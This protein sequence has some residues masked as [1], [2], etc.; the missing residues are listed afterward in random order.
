[1]YGDDNITFINLGINFEAFLDWQVSLEKTGANRV[2]YGYLN[3]ENSIGS[4]KSYLEIDNIPYYQRIKCE[5][6]SGRIKVLFQRHQVLFESAYHYECNES[7]FLGQLFLPRLQNAFDII[8]EGDNGIYN[9]IIEGLDYIVPLAKPG[10]QNHPSFASALLK[11]TIFLSLDLLETSDV[12]LAECIIHEFGHCQLYKV[13]D[14]VLLTQMDLNKRYYYSPWRTDPRHL[15]GLVHGIYVFSC[16]IDFYHQ[17]LRKSS[18][19]SEIREWVYNRLILLVYQ[20][21]CA[22][23]QVRKDEIAQAGGILLNDI[24]RQLQETATT[25]NID[26]HNC[27]SE[28]LEHQEAWKLKNCGPEFEIL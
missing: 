11:R 5:I 14:T 16:V 18:I 22:I 9:K 10:K 7:V 23:R 6:I 20:V 26:L 4:Q 13:Q 8:R 3:G 12:Y 25:L 19:S 27:H 1:N 17:L 21:F 15:L 24:H 28:L 2:A